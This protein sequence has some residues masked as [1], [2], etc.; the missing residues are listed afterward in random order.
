MSRAVRLGI[1][2]VTALTMLAVGSFL[3][4][5]R[6]LLFARKYRIESTFKTVGGLAE[7]AEV[8]VGG[9]HQGVVKRIQLP[10]QPNAEVTVVMEIKRSAAKVV[11]TDSV[12]AI[13]TEGLLGNKFVDISFGSPGAA[14]VR[15]GN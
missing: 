13:Y 2:I 3:I 6:Q 12:A 11:R 5:D 4:G 1:F 7:G 15:D 10:P 9:M 8:R 14:E